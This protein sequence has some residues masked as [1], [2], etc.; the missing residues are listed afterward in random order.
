ML[1]YVAGPYSA[2]TDEGVDA[3]IEAAGRIAAQLWRMGHAAICPHMNTAKMERWV[4]GVT[5][6]D[7]MRGDL[8][9][10]SR[11]DAVVMVPGWENSRGAKEEHEYAL[12]LKIPIHYAP[13]LP[14]L[15]PTEVRCPRQVK[16]FREFVGRMYRVHLDKNADYSPANILATGDIG[17]A[18]RL[19]DKVARLLNLMGFRFDI[20]PDSVRYEAPRTPKNESIEDTLMDAAVY[21]IIGALLRAGNWGR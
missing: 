6:S 12:A 9:M 3:N 16:A 18:T 20:N 17:L 4:E 19:W 7:Y 11:C 2:P 15:H 10:V 1:I 21:S 8:D 13:D 14:E 5:Y